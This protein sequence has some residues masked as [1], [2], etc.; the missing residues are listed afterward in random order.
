VLFTIRT[1]DGLDEIAS[2][3]FEAILTR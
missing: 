2:S 1:E 3:A